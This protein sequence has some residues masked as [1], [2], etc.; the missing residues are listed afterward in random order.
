M[1]LLYQA[2]GLLVV[3][4]LLRPAA[5]FPAEE[6]DIAFVGGTV[7][8]GTG[9][10][11]YQADVG[12]TESDRRFLDRYQADIH[13]FDL[14]KLEPRSKWVLKG[15]RKYSKGVFYVMV[16]GVLVLDNEKPTGKFPGAIINATQAWAGN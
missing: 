2:A 13:V 3:L 5:A 15:S 16:N 8:D 11:R 6:F 4:L 9:Q 10:K 1:R 12:V 7:V 14:D